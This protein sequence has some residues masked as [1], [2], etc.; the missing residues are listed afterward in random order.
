MYTLIIS[1]S[2]DL[3]P[4]IGISMKNWSFFP[5]RANGLAACEDVGVGAVG[6]VARARELDTCVGGLC[7]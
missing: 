1:M 3:F 2:L 7:S 6:V 4:L 5:L